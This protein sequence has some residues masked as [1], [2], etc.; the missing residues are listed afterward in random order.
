MPEQ[1]Y[2]EWSEFTPGTWVFGGLAGAGGPQELTGF[3][4]SLL[5]DMKGWLNAAM[6]GRMP[7]E[8]CWS[9]APGC[10]SIGFLLWHILRAEDFWVQG[11][12][13]GIPE[14]YE[15]EGWQRRL[16]TPPVDN[17]YQYTMEQVAN[18]RVPPME[19][20]LEYGIAVRGRTLDFLRQ[21]TVEK[22]GEILREDLRRLIMEVTL[23]IGQI[24]Y[25]RGIQ[26]G[27]GG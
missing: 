7:Q 10:N 16:G 22:L 11:H 5:S 20:L 21:F 9:P 26:R 6:D 3:V 15:S 8:M 23:H 25:L 17:G 14:I 19:M 1:Q 4:E 2:R 27:L 18:L 12:I 13:Q 24:A